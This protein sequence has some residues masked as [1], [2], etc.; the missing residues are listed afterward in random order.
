[1]FE[2]LE[3]RRLRVERDL[4]DWVK[5]VGSGKVNKEDL[6]EVLGILKVN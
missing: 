3:G 1:M 4:G 5:D 6:E 2:A